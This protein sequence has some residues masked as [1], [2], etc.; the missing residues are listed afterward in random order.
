MSL[1]A[2]WEAAYMA[3]T[4]EIDRPQGAPWKLRVGEHDAAFSHWLAT[5]GV[6]R[7][8]MLTAVN[9]RSLS[10][11]S[12]ENES[13]MTELTDHLERSGLRWRKGRSYG[14]DGLWEMEPMAW[15][16]DS[17]QGTASRFCQRWEQVAY[18]YGQRETAPKLFFLDEL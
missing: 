1:R 11:S 5:R 7:W 17:P 4:Y 3:T 13:R 9:P 12:Q 18:L 16:P 15:L 14:D 8:A 6:H 2:Q 10:L